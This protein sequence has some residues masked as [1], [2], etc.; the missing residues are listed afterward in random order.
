[1]FS[2]VLQCRE[3]LANVTGS[4]GSMFQVPVS[5]GS[6]SAEAK[7]GAAIGVVLEFTGKQHESRS[8]TYD[9]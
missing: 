9:P 4:W 5:A 8:L 1:M 6:S 2:T 7:R 3:Y